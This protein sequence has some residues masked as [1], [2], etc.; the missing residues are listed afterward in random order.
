VYKPKTHKIVAPRP[1]HVP[2]LLTQTGNSSSSRIRNITRL[3]YFLAPLNSAGLHT[4]GP[5]S[6][7][8]V[9]LVYWN[10]YCEAGRSK[11]PDCVRVSF[12]APTMCNVFRKTEPVR[13]NIQKS[14]PIPAH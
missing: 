3:G 12:R 4:L 8:L 11:I 1:L 13:Q 14:V 5:T 10:V 7:R 9:C 2:Y 6:M